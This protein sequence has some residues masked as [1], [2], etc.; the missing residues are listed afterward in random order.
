[1]ESEVFFLRPP[2]HPPTIGVL[3]PCCVMMMM[4]TSL[5]MI[6]SMTLYT[7]SC[8]YISFGIVSTS[9]MVIKNTTSDNYISYSPARRSILGF[10]TCA[11]SLLQ[12]L[13]ILK[14]KGT[15]FPNM[16]RLV[17]KKFLVLSTRKQGP[18]LAGNHEKNNNKKK[19][20]GLQSR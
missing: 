1:M 5:I 17:K 16:D 18:G 15:V 19:C 12:P 3:T 8:N 7:S 10:Q 13:P 4:M 20:P 11:C 9:V 14:I 2:L 6:A